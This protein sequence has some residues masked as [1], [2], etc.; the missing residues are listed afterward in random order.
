[1]AEHDDESEPGPSKRQ[2][3]SATRKWSGAAKY[4]TRFQITW[5]EAWPFALPEEDNPYSFLCKVCVKKVSCGHQGER[6][7]A[8]HA[9]SA[10]HQK[11]AKAMKGIKPLGFKLASASD[12]LKDKVNSNFQCNYYA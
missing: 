7:V 5:Q 12:P 6:D 1:M 8:R 11:N 3:T 9:A 2:K 4:K 10:Q